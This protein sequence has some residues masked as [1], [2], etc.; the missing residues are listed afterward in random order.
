[1]SIVAL[2]KFLRSVDQKWY[3]FLDVFLMKGKAGWEKI[4]YKN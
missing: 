1:M 2:L 4:Y 3:N